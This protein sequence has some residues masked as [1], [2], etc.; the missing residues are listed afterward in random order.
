MAVAAEQP[1]TINL[2]IEHLNRTIVGLALPSVAE[3]VLQTLVYFVDTI[4]ISRLND[5]VA[6]AAVGLSG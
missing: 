4:L 1:K 5:P 3:S 6:L 2:R